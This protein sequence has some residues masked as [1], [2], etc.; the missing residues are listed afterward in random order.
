MHYFFL[1][2]RGPHGV[3]TSVLECGLDVNEFKLGFR[4]YLFFQT[5]IIGKYIKH[6]IL[7]SIGWI[8]SPLFFYKA[9]FGTKYP[10][11]VHM[12]LNKKLSYII[13]YLCPSL[14]IYS[15]H[16]LFIYLSHIFFLST[17]FS[18]KLFIYQSIYL[19][20]YQLHFA[21][22]LSIYISIYLLSHVAMSVYSLLID[23]C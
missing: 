17:Y 23:L 7:P 3:K 10:T 21:D 8:V 9:G 15:G 2:G 20:I 11:K 16:T 4:Y 18:H 13:H 19:S 5:Y 12:P 14:W 22:Y 1:Q 6:L